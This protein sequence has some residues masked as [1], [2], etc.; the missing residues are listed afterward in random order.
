MQKQYL[1]SLVESTDTRNGKVFTYS[2]Q[3]LIILSLITFSIDTLPDL[4]VETKS[5]LFKIEAITVFIFTAE[6]LLRFYVAENKFKY[7]KSFYGVVDLCA[8][9]PFYMASGVDLRAIRI[10]RL[11]R[12]V[13]ILKLIKYN[14]AINRFARA[15]AIAREEL[16]LFGFVAAMLIYLSSVGI[17]ICEHAAQPD[18]FRSVFHSLWWAVIT[19]TTVGYGDMYPITVGGKIFTSFILIIGLGIVAIPTGLIASA[20]SKAREEE[21][22]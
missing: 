9:L 19:L 22:N 17:Y 21:N 1:K 14:K 16:I 6:Y 5:L 3:C 8:I 20:L 12:L 2:I 11:L 18:Q 7:V 4:S 15:F 10:L 13:R